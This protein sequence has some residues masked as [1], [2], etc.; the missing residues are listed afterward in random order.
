MEQNG[1]DGCLTLGMR[2]CTDKLG[3]HVQPR[4]CQYAAFYIDNE[5]LLAS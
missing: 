3:V 4:G 2:C 5:P 1:K